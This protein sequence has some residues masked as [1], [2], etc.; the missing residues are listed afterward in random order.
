M[1]EAKGILEDIDR[2]FDEN[3]V[4]VEVIPMFGISGDTGTVSEILIGISVN[5][6]AV[7]GSGTGIFPSTNPTVSLLN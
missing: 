1:S 7:R 4:F 6:F 3:P 2:S 5:A